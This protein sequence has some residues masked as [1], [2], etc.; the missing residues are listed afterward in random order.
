MQSIITSRDMNMLE[1][2]NHN[3]LDQQIRKVPNPDAPKKEYLNHP[4]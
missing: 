1:K 4:D 2:K 3:R